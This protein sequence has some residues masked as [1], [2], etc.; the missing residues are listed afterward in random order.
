MALRI[1]IDTEANADDYP[2]FYAADENLGTTVGAG[3]GAPLQASVTGA[4]AGDFL[5]IAAASDVASLDDGES[6]PTHLL[7]KDGS[8]MASGEIT[9]V[10]ASEFRLTLAGPGSKSPPSSLGGDLGGGD[11]AVAWLRALSDGFVLFD[12]TDIHAKLPGP[13]AVKIIGRGAPL[14]RPS[15]SAGYDRK[16]YHIGINGEKLRPPT[17][18]P[19]PTKREGLPASVDPPSL[20]DVTGSEDGLLQTPLHSLHLELGAK[21]APFAGYEMPLWYKSVGA[22]HQAV[23]RDAGVL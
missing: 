19:S 8:V 9:R 2:H 10:S 3:S 5:H 18:N 13:V 16:A 15:A 1:G 17:L 4:A 23:R 21:M 12:E 20:S 11:R 7:E 6:Q 22:E 14:G